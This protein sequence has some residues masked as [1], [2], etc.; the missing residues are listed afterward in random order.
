MSCPDDDPFGSKY[1]GKPVNILR[2]KEC[3]FVGYTEFY[4]HT[5]YKTYEIKTTILQDT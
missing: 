5:Y 1:V 2:N 4:T 3:A